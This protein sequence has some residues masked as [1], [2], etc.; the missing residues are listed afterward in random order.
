M[1]VP[2]FCTRARTRVLRK[3]KTE[4]EADPDYC[5]EGSN[6]SKGVDGEPEPS[7]SV[8]IGNGNGNPTTP[9]SSDMMALG[10]TGLTL[11]QEK[12]LKAWEER[13]VVRRSKKLLED[14]LKPKPE[15]NYIERDQYSIEDCNTKAGQVRKARAAQV[16][17]ARMLAKLEKKKEKAKN[18]KGRK[19]AKEDDDSEEDDDDSFDYSQLEPIAR[20]LD[21]YALYMEQQEETVDMEN[22]RLDA[23]PK[24]VMGTGKGTKG[25]PPAFEYK[26]LWNYELQ[27]LEVEDT[28]ED[29]KKKEPWEE[30]DPTVPDM[31]PEIL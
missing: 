7:S 27:P 10:A 31:K 13:R 20:E 4:Q 5:P 9:S 25:G 19:G 28:E 16:K 12:K 3:R 26:S 21:P 11:P 18:K 30:K 2:E 8:T 22:F 14:R 15:M 1:E 23:L 29:I 6:L 24:F 17:R